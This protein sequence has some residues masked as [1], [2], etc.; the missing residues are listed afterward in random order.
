MDGLVDKIR[1]T[2]PTLSAYSISPTLAT[3]AIYHAKTSYASLVQY[4]SSKRTI[5]ETDAIVHKI[6]KTTYVKR[7]VNYFVILIISFIFRTLI[8]TALTFKLASNNLYVDFTM[9]CILSI[10]LCKN[11]KYIYDI[12]NYFDPI[13]YNMITKK[14]I[15]GY[16][17]QKYDKISNSVIFSVIIGGIAFASVYDI[18][19]NSHFIIMTLTQY[20]IYYIYVDVHE[21]PQNSV[22]RQV[23]DVVS[24]V[25]PRCVLRNGCGDDVSNTY[26]IIDNVVTD[27]TTRGAVAHAQTQ[28]PESDERVHVQQPAFVT[29][30]SLCNKNKITMRLINIQLPISKEPEKPE[31]PK[32]I[33]DEYDIVDDYGEF[34][35]VDETDTAYNNSDN[36]GAN[37]VT[38]FASKF[39]SYAAS[40]PTSISKQAAATTTSHTVPRA[41]PMQQKHTPPHV[42][43]GFIK[44]NNIYDDD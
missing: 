7:I 23:K 37:V 29:N 8:Y 3:D 1:V 11:N 42:H 43:D 31:I 32:D 28:I 24:G 40:V 21:N 25:V 33:L 27:V 18:N 22:W 20:G 41:P 10:L 38:N 26:L 6:F 2:F 36:Y 13:I 9:Q 44:V 30:D 34:E 15:N 39:M 5:P 35:I 17:K 4:V 12:V 19:I 16:S 14:C